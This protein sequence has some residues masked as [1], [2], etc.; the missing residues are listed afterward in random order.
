MKGNMEEKSRKGK[1]FDAMN[2]GEFRLYIIMRFFFI[3]ALRMVGTVVGWKIYILTRNPLALGMIGLSEVIPAVS[4]ALY[5]GH[6]IDKSDKRKM[7]LKTICFYLLCAVALLIIHL[8]VTEQY[9]G[10]KIIEVSIYLVIFCTGIIRSFSGPISHSIIAQLVPKS[11]L[12]NAI[13]WSSG[14]WL[15][16]SVI[17]HA[18]A[19]FLIAHAGY[20]I[21]FSVIISYIIIAIACIACIS[22]KPIVHL[23]V[24]QKTWESM[25]EGLRHVFRTK[26]L[27]GALSLDLFAVLFGGAVALIPIFA[28]DILKVGA[29]G[30]GWLN[31]A[32]D[33]GAISS[34]ALLTFFPLQ[35]NQGRILLYA[36]AGFGICIILF[37]ISKFFWLSFAALMLSGILDGISVVVR[38]TI[39]QLKTPD[40]MRGR[41]SSINS[42][43]INSS[44]E[45]GQFESGVAAKLVGVIPSVVLGGCMTLLVVVIT[46][47]K[48]PSLRK[49][50]Y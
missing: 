4:L 25:K 29:E 14:T 5:A 1:A 21:T 13:T 35:K 23:N 46:W 8:D 32:A 30:F 11:I 6:V 49:L 34:I 42:M 16:A 22:P 15:I 10:K 27:L 31:A 12:P 50:E 41:V 39:L 36:V 3:M 9:A 24:Q 18:T 20:T 48:A 7:L 40:S 28:A 44:N 37:G 26:E 33:M 2:V 19:G 43:F 47:I 38:S 17:G 45:L